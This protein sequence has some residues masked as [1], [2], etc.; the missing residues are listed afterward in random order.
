LTGDGLIDLSARGSLEDPQLAGQVVIRQARY[1]NYTSGTVLEPMELVLTGAERRLTLERLEA[2]DGRDGSINGSGSLTWLGE[3]G[4]LSDLHIRFDEMLIAQRD[5][6][7]ARISGGIDVIGNLFTD[8][9][10][11]GRL[12]ND[13]IEVRLVDALP[14]SVAEIQVVEVRDGVPATPE[15]ELSDEAPRPSPIALNVEIDLPR[16][17]FVRGRGLESEWRG[18]FLVAGTI[19]SP[20]ISGEINPARGSFT[21]VGK[22]FVLQDSSIRLPVGAPSLDPELDLTAVYS[23]PDFRALVLVTGAASNPQIELSSEPELPQDEILSRVLFNKNSA[24][25]T[26]MEAI[27]LADA[28]A[29]LATGG[30]GLTGL[31]RRSLGVDEFGFRPGETEDDPGSVAVGTYLGEGVYVGVQQGIR[32]GS[33]GVTVEIDITDTIKAHSDMGVDGRNRSGVRWQLDY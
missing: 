30:S 12:T 2:S 24:N 32:P 17:V 27:E 8:A 33:T 23:T 25:L 9:L 26:A 18:Q 19:S 16:R 15:E 3:E 29:G 13:F 11:S 4:L 21:V 14:P 22:T 28:A 7:T 5:D 6:V 31:M 1:E 10:I 20:Q